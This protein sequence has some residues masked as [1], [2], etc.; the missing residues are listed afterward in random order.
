[1]SLREVSVKATIAALLLSTVAGCTRKEAGGSALLSQLKQG[2]TDRDAKIQSYR[3]AGSASQQGQQASFAFSYRAPNKM[4]GEL[5]LP[6]PRTFSYDGNKLYELVPDEKRFVSYVNQLPPDRSALFLTQTF[7]PF[8][9]EGFRA[10]LMTKADV[11]ATKVTHPR[12]SEA[13]ELKVSADDGSGTPMAVTYT[14]RWPALDFL[15]KKTEGSVGSGEIKVEDEQCEKSL[16]LCFPKKLTQWQGA[17]LIAT[18]TLDTIE[19]NPTILNDA[20][21]LTAPEGFESKEQ[22]LVPR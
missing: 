18:T 19:I 9:P 7:A 4:R 8:A 1:L 11:V 17:D 20:F 6:Q 3:L 14:L 21:T 15:G 10:P 2:L 13:V 5:K 12:A 16:G 22:T